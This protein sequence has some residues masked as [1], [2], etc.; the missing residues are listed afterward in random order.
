MSL[1]TNGK[2]QINECFSKSAFRVWGVFFL[3]VGVISA[4]VLFVV[5]L[6]KRSSEPF[7]SVNFVPTNCFGREFISVEVSNRM[8][9]NLTTWIELGMF[10]DQWGQEPTFD[11]CL[12]SAHS[13][14]Q[15]LSP[16]PTEASIRVSVWYERQLKPFEISLQKQF[17]LA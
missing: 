8:S 5:Y 13:Q 1:F 2:E 4:F 9:F 17:P 16:T 10:V 7:V 15:L 11:V 14:K 12:L 6:P 3:S